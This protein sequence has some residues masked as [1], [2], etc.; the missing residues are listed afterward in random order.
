MQLSA[1]M[2]GKHLVCPES[3]NDGFLTKCVYIMEELDIVKEFYVCI[4]I[5]RHKQCPVIIYSIKGGVTL[6]EAR[7]KHPELL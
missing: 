5:D 4:T 2:C 7:E 1:K 6:E 3:G